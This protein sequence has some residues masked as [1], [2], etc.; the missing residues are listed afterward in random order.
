MRYRNYLLVI[1]AV[2]FSF[3][4]AQ[5]AFAHNPTHVV[6]ITD[7]GYLPSSLTIE[8]GE[9]ILFQNKS[10]KTYWPRVEFQPLPKKNVRHES[11][12]ALSPGQTWLYKFDLIGT[13]YYHDKLNPK[14]N[15]VA[16]VTDGS[17]NKNISKSLK[18]KGEASDNFLMNLVKS[19]LKF[20]G[21]NKNP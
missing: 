9:K 16:H 4:N 15:G 5:S 10:K 3:L 1:V 18:Q 19:I 2:Y 13:W 7:Q 8:R 11:P 12:R 21:I 17:R 20:L 14:I 6:K